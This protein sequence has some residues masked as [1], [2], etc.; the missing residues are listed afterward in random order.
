[1]ACCADC[2]N[3]SAS[4]DTQVSMQLMSNCKLLARCCKQR[5]A[6]GADTNVLWLEVVLPCAVKGKSCASTA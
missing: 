1:M 3:A 2:S 6:S 4:T 5:A